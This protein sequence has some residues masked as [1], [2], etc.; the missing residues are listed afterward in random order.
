MHLK[1][2]FTY[3][4][5]LI[6]LF[7]LGGYSCKNENAW[8][9][10]EWHNTL[11]H[12][13]K[14]FN[15]EQNW[16]TTVE[17][18]RDAY[19]EDFRQPIELFNYGSLESLQ[20]NLAAMDDVIKRS[21]TMIDKHPK[22]RWVD[23]AYLLTGKAYLFKG[24]ATAAINIFD[25]VNSQ[26]PD[27]EI[28]FLAKLWTVRALMLK[29][30]IVDAEAL[31]INISESSELPKKL[32]PLA[33]FT[34]GAVYHKEKKYHL[35]QKLL[36]E[37]LPFLRNRMDKYR[38]YFALGQ[39]YQA[40]EKYKEAELFYGRIPRFNPPYEIAFNA[41]IEQVSILS[42]KQKNY[43]KA[44]KIL[45]NMLKD[46]KNLDFRGQIYYRIALNQINAKQTSLALNTL[47]TSVQFSKTDKTQ[48]TSSYLKLGDLYFAQRNFE[49][50]G[51][52]Y[53]SAMKSLD[54][55]H[56]DFESIAAKNEILSDL[57][58]HL[59]RI[60]NNDSLIRM[61]NDETFR[62]DKIKLA[63]KAEKDLADKL[64]TEKELQAQKNNRNNNSVM[65]G[66]MPSPTINS[67][68]TG[69]SFPFYNVV[70]RKNGIN[71]FNK[72]WGSR[73]NRDFWRY[74]VKSTEL[75]NATSPQPDNN[76]TNNSDPSKTLG[77]KNTVDSSLL[78][79]VPEDE[80]K[81]YADLPFDSKK[82]GLMKQEIEVSLFES[83]GIYANRLQEY[84]QAINQFEYLIKTHPNSAY[85]PQVF[86]ELSKLYRSVSDTNKS[87][88]F[89]G[90][91]KSEYPNSIYVKMTENPGASMEQ[92]STANSNN[93]VIQ[94]SYDTLVVLFQNQKYKQA[95]EFKLNTDKL[96]SGNALQPRFDFIYAMCLL[97][98]EHPKAM[99]YF[100]QI[101]Q[102]YP[103]TDVSER[104]TNLINA[105]ERRKN[106]SKDSTS[107]VASGMYLNDLP[108][109]PMMC[110]MFIPKGSNT[111]LIKAGINDLNNKEFSFD[112]LIIGR[113][114]PIST[115]NLILIENFPNLQKARFY[116]QYLAKQQ[117][118]FATKGLFEYEIATISK[119]NLQ[120]LVGSMNW[121]SYLDW[122]KAQ[123]P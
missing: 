18:V 99:S 58:E 2:N 22:S 87:N 52:Y 11:A 39:A 12:Y 84:Q 41:Q 112:E 55:K 76:N 23:D 94:N 75:A 70:T 123:N 89:K 38:T 100:E 105:V 78:K 51:L 95:I 6:A 15:A 5:L 77:E 90:Q 35:S 72:K 62:K 7:I 50:S 4:S 71:E 107:A 10:K 19:K 114:I 14:F 106:P 121:K 13:N 3:K 36:R 113:S 24:D 28:K 47:K 74:N 27:P 83:G 64:Q 93:L 30:K 120:R 92:E 43:M 109:N 85:K 59:L 104:A 98:T 108:N 118:Y 66:G 1:G 69:S 37:A 26:Y 29:N 119:D 56:P 61:V 17:T 65:P 110:I 20:S 45:Q 31:A 67:G 8:A 60:R 57:L 111:N 54:E 97:K 91:L 63:K 33:Q 53:D 34:L 25:F 116:Q 32:K 21:S 102:D 101:V 16:L 103:N 40:T 79:N 46:D 82:Q 80:R 122:F 86:Y 73:I 117:D 96:Y 68:G 44:N 49:T 48:L 115:G 88:L 9:Y 42:V 81:Y